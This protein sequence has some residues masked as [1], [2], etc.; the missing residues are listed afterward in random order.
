MPKYKY[1]G[2]A[3]VF[4]KDADDKGTKKGETGVFSEEMVERYTKRGHRFV[5]EGENEAVAVATPPV[6][7]NDN[8][9]APVVVK[10]K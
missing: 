10:G 2:F 3:N 9:D 8:I 7:T 6:I 4:Y 5:K 1:M